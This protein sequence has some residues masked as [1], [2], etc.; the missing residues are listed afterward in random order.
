MKMFLATVGACFVGSLIW[1]AVFCAA[2]GDFTYY[3]R[4]VLGYTLFCAVMYGMF[5]RDTF[6]GNHDQT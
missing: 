4:G 2:I 6:G 1:G 5:L 3:I